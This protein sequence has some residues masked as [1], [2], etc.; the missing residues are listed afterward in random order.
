[1]DALG[2]CRRRKR[3]SRWVALP[4]RHVSVQPCVA[5]SAEPLDGVRAC[6]VVPADA[7]LPSEVLRV[8]L[9]K[10]R[11]FRRYEAFQVRGFTGPIPCRNVR[12]V[13]T[14]RRIVA[15]EYEIGPSTVAP[16]AIEV[17]ALEYFQFPLAEIREYVAWLCR[18]S[19]GSERVLCRVPLY[20][21]TRQLCAAA[22][23]RHPDEATFVPFDRLGEAFAATLVSKAASVFKAVPFGLRTLAVCRAAVVGSTRPLPPLDTLPPD[24]R[25]GDIWAAY[26]RCCPELVAVTPPQYVTERMCIAC[27]RAD[28]TLYSRLPDA[29]RKNPRVVSAAV[30]RYPALVSLLPEQLLVASVCLDAVRSDPALIRCIPAAKLTSR[31]CRVALALDPSLIDAVPRKHLTTCMLSAFVQSVTR[32]RSN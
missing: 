4:L 27:V 16:S 26:V 1:M 13:D 9:S 6:L 17:S 30:R 11:L 8:D 22:V 12:H 19:N 28:P 5:M 23:E 14:L 20:M 21:R 24:S 25:D 29:F 15:G 2:N 7:R 32:A 18:V 3:E 10:V 31:V